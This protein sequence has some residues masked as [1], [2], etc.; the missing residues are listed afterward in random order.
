[1]LEALRCERCRESHGRVELSPMS[2]VSIS[3]GM[4]YRLSSKVVAQIKSL[5]Q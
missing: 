2:G 3:G 5:I 4:G 1:M